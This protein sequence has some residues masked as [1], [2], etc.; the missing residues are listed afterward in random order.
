MR[1]EKL[2][3]RILALVFVFKLVLAAILPMSGDEAYFV[4]WAQHP[5]IG[6]YDH[7]PM[8]AW[9]LALLLPFGHADW[10]VRL[11]AVVMSTLEGWVIWR[12][13]RPAGQAQA[14]LAAAVYL[15][16]PFSLVNVLVTT[17]TPLIFFVL[18]SVWFLVRAVRDGCRSCHAWSGLM[19]GLAFLSKYFAVVLVLAYGFWFIFTA[20]GRRHWR[21]GL[22]LLLAALPAGLLNLFWN[23]THCWDNILFNAYNRNTGITLSWHDLLLYLAMTLYMVT[24]PVAWAW[25]HERRQTGSPQVGLYGFV[26]WV[27]TLFFLILST[28]KTIGLHWVLAFYPFLFLLLGESLP[29]DR[30]RGLLRFMSGFALLHVLVIAFLVLSPARW[31]LPARLDSGYVL[32]MQP[33]AVLSALRPLRSGFVVATNDYS[34]SAVMAWHDRQPWMVY[35]EGSKHAREDDM[36][37]DFRQLAGRNILVFDKSPTGDEDYAPYFQRIV[38]HQLKIGNGVFYVVQGYGFRYP[39]YRDV[40]LR[41]IRQ[42]Y[43]RI[44]EWLP[45]TPCYFCVRYFPQTGCSTLPDA[46]AT[47]SPAHDQP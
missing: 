14:A 7:P 26:W 17:D 27:P 44:P 22:I 9:L 36:L 3:W 19:L 47:Q 2:F 20:T 24:P 31:W 40:V 45:H 1:D 29:V 43:Y 23:V 25:W 30:M 21:G 38:R 6:Y 46:A 15:V 32:L 16:W 12:M 18:L 37:T 13:L 34:T 8:V 11:P 33:E 4:V 39:A 5:D 42:R 28:G 35:G 10:L 41:S